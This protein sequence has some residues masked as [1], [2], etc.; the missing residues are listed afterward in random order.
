MNDGHVAA[1]VAVKWYCKLL[2]LSLDE[3]QQG[4]DGQLALAAAELAYDMQPDPPP[5][6]LKEIASRLEG[7]QGP[8]MFMPISPATTDVSPDVPGVGGGST[9]MDLAGS[10]S[11][12]ALRL[13]RSL[14]WA[15][16]Y[17]ARKQRRKQEGKTDG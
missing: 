2:E 11:A 13:K 12:R 8:T 9:D 6:V 1:W 14:K 3:L 4:E 7:W 17:L 15:K 5:S 16:K 10:K